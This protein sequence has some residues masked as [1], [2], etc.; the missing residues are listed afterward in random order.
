MGALLLYFGITGAQEKYW[1]APG[2]A[3]EKE[4]DKV[5]RW[6]V[7]SLLGRTLTGGENNSARLSLRV[8][9]PLC[10]HRTAG[11]SGRIYSFRSVLLFLL[12]WFISL[13]IFLVLVIVV[14]GYRS[15]PLLKTDCLQ[16]SKLA[17]IIK[18]DSGRGGSPFH[19]TFLSIYCSSWNCRSA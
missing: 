5:G 18:D 6:I 1:I 19:L 16:Y 13:A 10:V 14:F 9:L 11:F 7:V 3:V 4:V 15:L 8:L 2:G 17:V 12:H